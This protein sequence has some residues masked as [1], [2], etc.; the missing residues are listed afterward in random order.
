MRRLW[1]GFLPLLTAGTIF[2]LSHQSQLPGGLELPHP[3]DWLAHGTA[4]GLLALGL[5][6]SLREFRPGLPIYKRHLAVFA[7]VL[8]FGAS[9][10]WHQSFIPGRDASLLDWMADASGA[11]L[12]LSLDTLAILRGRRLG[13][14]SWWRGRRERPDPT[15]PLI[16]VA[17]PHWSGALTGLHEATATHPEAD[18][19]FLGDVFDVWV[20]LRGMQAPLQAEF[21]AWVGERRAAGRWVGLWLGNREYFL[22]G[23]ASC[24]DL[25]GEGIGG[26]LPAEGLRFEHGDLINPEDWRYRIWNLVT[27][28]G[29]VWL[30]AKALPAAWAAR[31]AR[32]LEGALRTTNTAYRMHF[33][34][35]AFARAAE[36]PGTFITG[37]FHQE[38]RI[39][40]G[41]AL[42]WA[43]EGQFQVWRAGRIEALPS[44]SEP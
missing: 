32:H 27:R 25:M 31:L 40:Q 3:L 6:W 41:H 26:E 5:E 21:L 36:G 2:A 4:Y 23:L 35:A 18:W 8:L 22:D 37:H 39:G 33:P 17:D 1:I 15:R 11:L 16:L 20:G 43:H 13:V 42:P 29:P 7:L 30:L 9:D 10:E 14:L 19:L 12:A 38:R 28:S 34:E 44:T 24:F